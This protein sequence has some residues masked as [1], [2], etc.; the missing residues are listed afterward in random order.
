M[1][2]TW[3]EMEKEQ[4]KAVKGILKLR[5]YHFDLYVIEAVIEAYETMIENTMPEI[6]EEEL[7][8][9]ILDNLSFD[10]LVENPISK[11]TLDRI[12]HWNVEYFKKIGLATEDDEEGGSGWEREDDWEVEFGE[13]EE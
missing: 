2:M 7:D 4:F 13:E 12:H 6:D 3:E 11:Q 8:A 5:G 10:P 9:F 1:K